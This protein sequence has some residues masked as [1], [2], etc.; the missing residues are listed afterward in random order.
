MHVHFVR[1]WLA[2]AGWWQDRQEKY[3]TRNEKHCSIAI[4]WSMTSTWGLISRK[5]CTISSVN[6]WRWFLQ[7]LSELVIFGKNT[8]TQ[9]YMYLRRYYKNIYSSSD[10]EYE[11][12]VPYTSCY[13]FQNDVSH[14][15]TW[16][17]RP[18]SYQNVAYLQYNM[19]IP[20]PHY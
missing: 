7:V 2:P 12:R 5:V 8:Q 6:L 14:K 9:N 19:T 11:N 3:F 15:L 18:P 4:P 20:T 13:R 17:W 1:L 10:A 16:C